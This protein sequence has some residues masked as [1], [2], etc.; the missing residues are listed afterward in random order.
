V[1]LR[2]NQHFTQPPPRF[3]E[4][5]LVKELEKLGIGRPSTYAQIISTIQDRGYVEPEKGRFHPTPLGDTVA[6]LLVRVFPD[7]FDVDFTSRME[8]ELDRVEEGDVRWRTLLEEFYGP[9]QSQLQTGK[10]NSEDIVKEL[11]AAEGETCD[12]CGRPMQV[13]WN[14]F[15][16]FLGCSGYPECQNTR[17]LDAPEVQERTLGT[18]PDSGLP[19]LARVGPYGPYVQLG[20]GNGK[21]KPKRVSIPEGMTLEDMSLNYALLLLSL[22]R[23]LGEDPK[24]GKEVT[25][26]IGRYGPY[27]H[28]G[29]TYRNL[30]T[31][32]LLFEIGL[33]QALELLETKPGRKVLKELGSHPASGE[34]LQV[35]DGRYGPY[36][37]DGSVN[38]SLPKTMEPKELEM[39]EAV[40]LLARAAARKGKGKGRRKKGGGGR[41]KGRKG[42]G[43]S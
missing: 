32:A 9:F 6:K 27:V 34:E 20:E 40:E 17:P 42:R 23:S 22:P 29:G 16:R 10:A 8:G 21:E 43:K 38:A 2:P 35:L 5:N 12:V 3:S 31:P 15:G 36:V 13:R 24:T 28:R 14:K 19:V 7:I 33:E 4:A 30:E 26:G 18:D 25:V 37:T 1:E 11:L 41:G 39:E